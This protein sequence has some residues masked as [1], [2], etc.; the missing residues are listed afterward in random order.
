VGVIGEYLIGK[1]ITN[2][3]RNSNEASFLFSSIERKSRVSSQ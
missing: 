2:G 3:V 1:S